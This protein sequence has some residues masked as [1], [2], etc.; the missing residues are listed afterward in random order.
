MRYVEHMSGGV[1][2]WSHGHHHHHHKKSEISVD[3][4][5]G[6]GLSPTEKNGSI[7][8]MPS[9]EEVLERVS[10]DSLPGEKQSESV[11]LRKVT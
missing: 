6:Q 3:D 8:K 2:N 7:M 11:V 1:N 5:D 4:V 9:E 10:D